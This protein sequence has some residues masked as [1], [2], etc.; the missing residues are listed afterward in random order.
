[1]INEKINQVTKHVEVPQVQFLLKTMEI[2][3]LQYSDNVVEVPVALV[4]QVPQ[5]QFVKK[6]VEGP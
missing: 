1:M 5:M 2:S 3:Q 6:T 4:V